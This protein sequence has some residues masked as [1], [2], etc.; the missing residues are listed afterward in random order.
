[1]L[2]PRLLLQHHHVASKKLMGLTAI[3]PGIVVQSGIISGGVDRGRGTA[4]IISDKK[5]ISR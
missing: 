4:K 3:K 2:L 5:N 1:M